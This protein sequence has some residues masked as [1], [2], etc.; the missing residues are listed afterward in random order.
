MVNFSRSYSAP[1]AS[2]A[3]ALG[4]SPRVI[5]PFLPQH[6]IKENTDENDESDNE[7]ASSEPISKQ[8][9]DNNQDLTIPNLEVSVSD[10]KVRI[11]QQR[12]LENSL[13]QPDQEVQKSDIDALTVVNTITKQNSVSP[14]YTQDDTTKTVAEPYINKETTT[15]SN[16][17]FMSS[18]SMKSSG[19]LM[20]T[21]S[22]TTKLV[23]IL[24]NTS[25]SSSS[26]ST[27]SSTSTAA[28]LSN[29]NLDTNQDSSSPKYGSSTSLSAVQTSTVSFSA[30]CASST[31][32][33]PGLPLHL[34]NY[35]NSTRDSMQRSQRRRHS[36]TNF[37]LNSQELNRKKTQIKF[38]PRVW[39]REFPRTTIKEDAWWTPFELEAMKQ[40][41]ISRVRSSLYHVNALSANR[42]RS[43][44]DPHASSGQ[45]RIQRMFFNH[46]ALSH[47]DHQESSFATTSDH[48][49]QKISNTTSNVNLVLLYDKLCQYELRSILL[50][51][52]HDM[53]LR[54][55]SKSF[56][57]LLPHS[58]I[59]TAKS[60]EE[61]LSHIQKKKALLPVEKGGKLHGFDLI[62]VEERMQGHM[63]LSM[64]QQPQEQE[65]HNNSSNTGKERLTN[66][67]SGS[68]LLAQFALE[69]QLLIEPSSNSSSHTDGANQSTTENDIN[70]D[71]MDKEMKVKSSFSF[72]IGVSAHIQ[73][74]GSKLQKAGASLVWSKPPPS[75]DR[76]LKHH[77]VKSIIQKRG[78]LIPL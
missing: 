28:S 46:P 4:Y 45:K 55:F 59:T 61:A 56:Q 49:K 34:M 26:I 64:Q 37:Y 71:N 16:M 25:N 41:A 32:L 60:I 15:V 67:A 31:M 47:H 35:H 12:N 27:L 58:K 50:V 70:H 75:F 30:D 22:S 78:K 40:D 65:T 5:F 57:T 66:N 2:R 62:L 39:V 54:L 68:Q 77:L 48:D 3:S 33:I 42:V 20:T 29:N 9:I 19:T 6:A 51:D 52:P 7:L 74:D 44:S 72:F 69:E 76:E 13:I 53:F 14:D 11:L 23:S 63:Y 1:S 18:D 73:S 17:A 8:D 10:S 36:T 43:H 24:R 38:D 21:P